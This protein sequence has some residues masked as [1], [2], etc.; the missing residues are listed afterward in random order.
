[1]DIS[2]E[3]PLPPLRDEL[4]FLQ[5]GDDVGA[6]SG[7]LIFDPVDHKYFRIGAEIAHALANWNLGTA[8]KLTE[9]MTR[10]GVAFGLEQVSDLLQFVSANRLCVLG[11]GGAQTLINQQAARKKNIFTTL[12]HN[13]LFFKVPLLHPHEML[14]TALPYISW[15]G[16]R[17]THIAILVITL[18]GLYLTAR[19]WDV[20]VHSFVNFTSWDGL[21]ILG[22][23]LVLLKTGHELGHAFV[24]TSYGCKVPVMGVAFLVLFP[25]LYSDVSDTW[26]LTDKSKRLKVDAAGMLVEISLGGICLFLWA[27]FPPGVLR[28]LCFFVATTGWIMS[29]LVNLSPFMRFDGYHI[30]A[31]GLG[32]HNL[33]ERGFA[34]GRWQ[35]RK[36][37]LGLKDNVPEAFSPKMHR[38]LVAYA[39]GT[40]VYR[41]FLFLGIAVLVY[42]MF[43]KLLG[44]LLFVVEII[45]FI[46]MPLYKELAVWWA[47]R[48]DIQ[49]NWRG[50]AFLGVVLAVVV[51]L[52]LPLQSKVRIPAIITSSNASEVYAPIAARVDTVFVKVGS[53]VRTGDVLARLVWDDHAYLLDKAQLRL[54]LSERRITSGVSDVEE[55][56]LRGV[57]LREVVALKSTI[58]GLESQR[59]SLVLKAK[60][61]GVVS[62]V[63]EGLRSGLWVNQETPL[64][65]IVGDQSD[66]AIKGLVVETDIE[67]LEVGST[68]V[69]VFENLDDKTIEVSLVSIGLSNATG[70][71]LN[72]LSSTND[73][74][75]EMKTSQQGEST[76]TQTH[77]P[78]TLIARARAPSFWPHEARGTIVIDG[79]RVSLAGRFFKH[80]ASVLIR[81]TGF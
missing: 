21:I 22:V 15:L 73:G 34:L 4:Q 45:W 60:F 63:L 57:L 53:V 56:A 5:A 77:Y 47:R 12:I 55:R 39:W 74:A 9:A 50:Q 40:W 35:L 42:V 68:G 81:E 79:K 20:F 71:E 8:G 78:V 51:G 2:E 36:S 59:Q 44:I 70:R 24:A 75:I 52:F 49:S 64:M 62:D 54:N 14:Q 27:V 17:A 26:R 72:Y 61:A 33:Q 32:I 41:F 23:A 37:L 19:Q 31:D 76:P 13:Y 28:D 25:M 65:N 7:F 3:T 6:S 69:F 10:R 43:F 30:L 80:I 1:M 48:K 18:F 67:R 38:T 58:K 29:V 46:A 66:F 11:A 16:K